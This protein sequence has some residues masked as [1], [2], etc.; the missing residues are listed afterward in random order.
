MIIKTVVPTKSNKFSKFKLKEH[1]RNFINFANLNNKKDSSF[2]MVQFKLVYNVNTV[3]NLTEVVVIDLNNK[4]DIRNLK[5]HI[6]LNFDIL[7]SK[8]LKQVNKIYMCHKISN[9]DE[10]LKYQEVIKK[11]FY[12]NLG[13]SLH[14]NNNLLSHFDFDS[15]KLTKSDQKQSEQFFMG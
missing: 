11:S 2:L 13:T 1:Y 15:L 8:G 3:C 6:L 5:E 12:L 10:Y 9:E 14:N 4:E 7:I